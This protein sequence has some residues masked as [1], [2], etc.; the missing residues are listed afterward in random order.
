[1]YR[2]VF[3]NGPSKGRRLAVGQ[4][5]LVIGRAP[6][7]HVMISDEHVEASHAILEEGPDGVYIKGAQLTT[8]LL[9]NGADV[10]EAKL[11]HGDEFEIGSV[12]ILYQ[13]IQ[14]APV[15]VKRRASKFH[16]MAFV[17]IVLII[18]AQVALIG[19]LL[20]FGKLHPIIGQSSV[21]SGAVATVPARGMSEAEDTILMKRLR[22]AHE[23]EIFPALPGES[24]AAAV[25]RGEERALL[26]LTYGQTPL[27]SE[28]VEEDWEFRS[29]LRL[30]E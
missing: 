11:R 27:R 15:G 3:L 6:D 5:R 16:G 2:L 13:L 30:Q 22:S 18:V 23:S 19:G 9:V 24:R 10:H 12:R 20:V 4:G 25:R 1:M 21:P 26:D 14:A 28:N 7:S 29:L 8:R 17:L